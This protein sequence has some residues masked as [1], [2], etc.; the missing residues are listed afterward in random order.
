MDTPLMP[1]PVKKCPRSHDAF[2]THVLYIAGCVAESALLAGVDPSPAALAAQAKELT[3]ANAK[4]RGGAPGAVANRDGKR[5]HLE[6]GLDHLVDAVK[7]VIISEGL[8]P[9]AAVTLILGAGLSVRKTGKSPKP[10]LAVK[11]GS[12]PGE[13]I[14]TA[15]AVAQPA[16]Y[17]WEVSTDQMTFSAL[18]DTLQAKTI[19][20]GLTPGQVYS[21]RFRVRS[22]KGMGAY[23]DAISLM[24]L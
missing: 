24:A 11:H 20:K 17:F 10:P 18:H 15:L 1:I 5:W 2:V 21:F 9:A 23:S 6:V 4:A 3:D 12:V 14:L 19:V 13:M 7:G 22:R 8:D 16:L